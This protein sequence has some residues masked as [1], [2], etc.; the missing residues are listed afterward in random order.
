MPFQ[1]GDRLGTYEI[2]SQLGAGGMGEVHQAKDTKLDREEAIKV[3]PTALAHDSDRL[4]RIER[5]ARVLASLNHPNIAQ[6]Y[7]VEKS[8]LVMELIPGQTLG[9]LMKPGPMPLATPVEY[10]RLL[11]R[12]LEHGEVVAY[13]GR[14]DA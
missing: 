8:V 6:N 4:A 2:L 7:G 3:L 14:L 11:K 10:L 13:E 9:S 1:A 5:E 12:Y